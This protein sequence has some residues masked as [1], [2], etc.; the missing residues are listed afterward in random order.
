VFSDLHADA[1]FD[2]SQRG[3]HAAYSI[4]ASIALPLVRGRTLVGILVLHNATPREWHEHEISLVEETAERTWAAVERARVAR[5]LHERE[6]WLRGQREA[7]EAAL[8]GAPLADSLGLL[9]RTAVDAL[10]PGTRAAFYLADGDRASLHHVV[11]MDDAYAK[12]VDGFAIGP[13]S[14]AY[15]LATATGQPVVT[16][17]VREEPLWKPWQWLAEQFGYRGCWSF[18][19]LAAGGTFIASL[20]IYSQHPRSATKRE[21]E[22]ASLLTQTA[23]IIISQHTEHEARRQAEHDLRENRREA[24]ARSRQGHTRT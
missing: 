6:A 15:G 24:T 21:T 4:L 14:L 19:I 18:P 12:A 1:R 22:L 16:T 17:D 23:S 5:T 13:E 3:A 7:L 11:G 8:N 20:A 2:A 9:V 10:G